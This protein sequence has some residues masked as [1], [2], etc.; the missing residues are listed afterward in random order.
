MQLLP[1]ASEVADKVFV[2][3]NSVNFKDPSMQAIIE[4]NLRFA[5]APGAK[6]WVDKYLVTPLQQRET[7]LEKITAVLTAQGL[8]GKAAD[9][10]RGQYSGPVMYASKYFM[11]HFDDATKM[12]VIHDRLMLDTAPESH[13]GVLRT[14]P[15]ENQVTIQYSQANAPAVDVDRSVKTPKTTQSEVPEISSSKDR[16]P[17]R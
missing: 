11:V 16:G 14:Y 13:K 12:P 8:T 6:L 2:F 15:Q 3:D 5:I 7:D 9:E 17:E 10:L 4:K 1:K